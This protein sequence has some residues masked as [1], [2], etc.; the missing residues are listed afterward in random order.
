MSL[1][2][3]SAFV[4]I[5]SYIGHHLVAHPGGHFYS[6]T[7]HMVTTLTEALRKEL[8]G[9]NIRVTVRNLYCFRCLLL[10]NNR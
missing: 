5:R 9:S 4:N 2:F 6:A 3:N 1:F 8:Q 10:E 7:K